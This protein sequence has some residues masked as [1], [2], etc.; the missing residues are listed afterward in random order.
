MTDVLETNERLLD[1]YSHS[2]DEWRSFVKDFSRYWENCV[3]LPVKQQ[4]AEKLPP[5]WRQAS[6]TPM[7]TFNMHKPYPADLCAMELKEIIL[8]M[9]RVHAMV[10]PSTMAQHIRLSI[11]D[12]AVGYYVDTRMFGSYGQ[13]HLPEYVYQEIFEVMIRKLLEDNY[14]PKR[15]KRS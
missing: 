6:Y 3:L 12:K 7:D 14:D 10:D 8:E 5:E 11:G 9:V 15:V 2:Y 1:Q 4:V 13:H